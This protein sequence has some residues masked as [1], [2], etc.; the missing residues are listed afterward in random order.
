MEEKTDETSGRCPFVDRC[1]MFPLFVN[2]FGLQVFK[3]TYCHSSQFGRC[4]RHQLAISGTMPEG[5]LL[6]NGRR[7][8]TSD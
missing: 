7:L 3:T 8:V 1:P 4:R 5:D 6:P 2:D